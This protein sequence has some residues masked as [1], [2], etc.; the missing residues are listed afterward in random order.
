[1]YLVAKRQLPEDDRHDFNDIYGMTKS[2]GE[3][4]S[5]RIMNLR[6]S[7]IVQKILPSH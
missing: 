7:I 3:I 5:N 6:C 1:M 4:K 2:L